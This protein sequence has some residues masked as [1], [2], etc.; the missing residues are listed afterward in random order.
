MTTTAP[1]RWKAIRKLNL[2]GFA[3]MLV[4]IGGVGGWAGT[5]QLSGAVIASGV[6]VVESNLRKVQ[7]PT[8][9]IVSE[10]LIKQGSVS[11]FGVSGDSSPYR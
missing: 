1:E 4:L 5:V 11:N 3:A 6:L 2:L 10:I 8:G 7:H 9:G